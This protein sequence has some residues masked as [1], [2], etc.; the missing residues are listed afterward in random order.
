MILIWYVLLACLAVSG[1]VVL[2]CFYIAMWLVAIVAAFAVFTFR[3]VSGQRGDQ[4][5]RKS[6]T[7]RL[8][9]NVPAAISQM[10]FSDRR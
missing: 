8:K 7:P 9:I 4:L 6:F 1:L 5:W 3:F 2:A 10:R